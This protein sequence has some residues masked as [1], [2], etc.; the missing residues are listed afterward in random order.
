MPVPPQKNEAYTFEA[1][2]GSQAD[3][4]IFQVNPTLAAGD[5]T[6]SIDGAALGNI[7][8]LPTAIGAGAV[9]TVDL[10]AA[11]MNGDRI[12][13]L[14]SDQA[15]AEWQDLLVTIETDTETFGGIVTAVWA[16]AERTLTSSALTT[17]AAVVGS[18]ITQPWATS[19]DFSITGLGNI[20]ARASLYFTIKRRTTDIDSSAVVQIEETAGLLFINGAVATVAGNGTLTV[21]D[22]VAG[23]VTVTLA[24][25]ET[26]KLR[27]VDGLQ[28]DFKMV[29]GA[30]L[31]QL[32]TLNRFNIS[33]V[34]TGAIA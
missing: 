5:V 8:A 1:T 17:V 12:A 28:Y 4:N 31:V 25:A 29:T 32:L 10:T 18:V 13:I 34:V 11:E 3:T 21:D 23:D 27:P 15:G 19:W 6:V 33:D 26:N 30:G 22:A 20:T 7:T 14:F 9:L 24:V 16:N 2:L